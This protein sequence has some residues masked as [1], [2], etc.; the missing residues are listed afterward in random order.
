MISIIVPQAHSN[1]HN[2]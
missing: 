1:L 2:L